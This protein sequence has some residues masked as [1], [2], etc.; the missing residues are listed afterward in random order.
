MG[1]FNAIKLKS[2]KEDINFVNFVIVFLECYFV[3]RVVVSVLYRNNTTFTELEYV[4]R[5]M[6]F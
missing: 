6:A 5:L 2:N 3:L 4:E 1:V